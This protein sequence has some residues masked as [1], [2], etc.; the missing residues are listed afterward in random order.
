MIVKIVESSLIILYLNTRGQTKLTLEKQ[1]QI[2]DLAKVYNV[3]ILHLQETDMDDN[4]FNECAF[5]RNKLGLS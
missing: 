3:D 1:L 4:S 5:I 2:E